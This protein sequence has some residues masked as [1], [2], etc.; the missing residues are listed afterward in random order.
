[1]KRGIAAAAGDFMN[2]NALFFGLILFSATAWAGDAP[3]GGMQQSGGGMM[4]DS[5]MN[6]MSGGSPSCQNMMDE[7]KPKVDA[8]SDAAM[9]SKAMKQMDMAKMAMDKGHTKTCMSDM[10]KVM[11]MIH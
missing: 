9:K 7:A 5:S 1:L 3:G 6:H 2:R 8:M 4:G 10:H 11:Q